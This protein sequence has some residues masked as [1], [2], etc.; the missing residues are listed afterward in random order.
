MTNRPEKIDIDLKRP[1]RLDEKIPFF[2]PEDPE[3][4]LQI[5]QAQVRKHNV[6]L[7]G[8]IDWDSIKD[9]LVGYS[10]AEIE[11]VLLTTGKIADRESGQIDSLITT[12][13]ILAALKD[14]VRSRDTRMLQYME[15]Q[16]VF[17]SSSREMLPDRFKNMPPDE[18]QAR[19]DGLRRE[20]RGRL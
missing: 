17:E 7:D 10:A 12:V 3:T 15:M 1:G 4:C 8:T 18:I 16:A 5:F 19:L 11:A 20:L 13:H 2:F 6:T 9:G 14:V